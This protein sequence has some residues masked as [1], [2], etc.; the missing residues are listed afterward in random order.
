M[1]MINN[2][3]KTLAIRQLPALARKTMMAGAAALAMAA[4]FATVAPITQAHAQGAAAQKIANHF[5]EVK[6]MMGEF[7]QFGPSGEQTGGKFFIER[8][9][10]VLFLYE[11]PSKIRVVS[12]GST[13]VVN[14]KKL[15]TWDT[16]PLSKTPLNLVLGDSID[17]S[18]DKV[19][20]VDES[21]DLTT[22]VVQ[23]Q[24]VFG[25]STITMMFD[26]AS[27]DL[28]QWTI[29]DAK[30]KDTTVMIFNVEEGVK[31]GK[32]T[33]RIDYNRIREARGQ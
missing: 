28:R 9:G 27:Y 31:F 8:P 22:V 7:V 11:E 20:S 17:L 33:F 1:T 24:Q 2:K 30:G 32:N 16:Y 13:V 4:A 19:K 14:N 12:D 23:D 26:P 6:T 25:D 3:P 10:R 29:R 18:G 21:T 5:T 15:D